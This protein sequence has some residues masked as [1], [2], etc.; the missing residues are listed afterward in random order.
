[1]ICICSEIL[2]FISMSIYE[3]LDVTRMHSSRMRAARSLTASCSIYRGPVCLGACVLGGLYAQGPACPGEGHACQGGPAG[4]EGVYPMHT[5]LWT[6]FLTHT[7][8]NITFPQLLLRGV[9]TC[10]GKYCVSCLLVIPRSIYPCL[11]PPLDSDRSSNMIL[12]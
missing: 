1:M 7:C 10:T 8:E 6:E 3:C 12:V 9:T 4:P 5:P 2:L 11:D